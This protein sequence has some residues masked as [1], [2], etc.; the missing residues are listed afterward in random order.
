MKDYSYVFNAHP[1]FIE[2]MYKNYQQDPAS[3]DDGWRVFFDGFEFSNNGHGVSD[4]DGNITITGSTFTNNS[5][6]RNGG[7]KT[8]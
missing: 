6:A 2:S 5:A 8:Q 1:T 4:T 7:A 3:V